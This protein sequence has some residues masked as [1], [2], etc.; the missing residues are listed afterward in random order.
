MGPQFW[1]SGRIGPELSSAQVRA[2]QIN[3]NSVSIPIHTEL[4]LGK[5]HGI[6]HRI[7]DAQKYTY[8]LDT[9]YGDDSKIYY[10]FF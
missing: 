8:I 7:L 10:H 6:H 2:E 4:H 1:L 9:K 3:H 5:I